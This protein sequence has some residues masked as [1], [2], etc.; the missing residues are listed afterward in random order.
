M[1]VGRQPMGDTSRQHELKFLFGEFYLFS[2]RFGALSA[3]QF[4]DG[5][6]G[7]EAFVPSFR[8][9]D[10]EVEVVALNSVPVNGT[11]PRLA[12]VGGALRYVVAQYPRYYVEVQGT[13]ED[14]LKHFSSKTRSTLRRKV[15]R[16]EELSKGAIYF[17]EYR[18]SQEL[19]G[20]FH[21]SAIQLARRTYQHRL[22]GAALPDSQ[23]FIERMKELA[24]RD[25][26][27]A[28]LLFHEGKAVAYLYCPAEGG[29]LHYA[30]LGY[31]PGLAEWSCGTVLQYLALERIF[32]EGKFGVFDFTP[33]EGEQKKL[34][35][36]VMKRCADIHYFRLT[37][38][39]AA[40]V[41]IHVM[42]GVASRQTVRFLDRIGLKRGIKRVLRRGW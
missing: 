25:Q 33:G 10:R 18:T 17:R 11:Y 1:N 14:Y 13:F 40:L 8:N 32:A 20:E 30:Y 23:D 26:V 3:A 4:S 39:N 37:L 27:R 28:Y 29:A 12:L 35:G 31:D 15:R 21:P 24:A 7:T 36:T 41:G 38:R 34:F 19:E 5:G 22:L 16:F 6:C 42:L 2:A 9:L